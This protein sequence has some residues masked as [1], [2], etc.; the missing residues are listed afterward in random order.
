[1]IVD[2][3]EFD[4]NLFVGFDQS[5]TILTILNRDIKSAS[6]YLRFIDS[7]TD[8]AESYY[9]DISCP[10]LKTHKITF[11]ISPYWKKFIAIPPSKFLFS[12]LKDRGYEV[13]LIL[14]NKNKVRRFQYTFIL[15]YL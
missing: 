13:D 7:K 14:P 9:S 6:D 2:T 15:I 11:S 8:N 4:N 3:S 1:M 10:Y 12:I 5:T